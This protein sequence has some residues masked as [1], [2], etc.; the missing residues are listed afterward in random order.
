MSH[1]STCTIEHHNHGVVVRGHLPLSD[2]T[3]LLKGWGSENEEA[4]I[5]LVLTDNLKATLVVANSKEDAA[6]WKREL[7]IREDNPDWLKSGRVGI[8][9]KTIYAVFTNNWEI[10][11]R[12]KDGGNA[13]MDSDDFGRCVFLLD[14]YPAWRGELSRVA[15]ACKEFAPLVPV[16]AE[17]EHL[18][19]AGCFEQLSRR[20]SDLRFP[21]G[22]AASR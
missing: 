1:L 9:S 2:L 3:T 4:S 11:Q 12:G 18:Y 13:P 7:D 19:A 16:W 17:L 8:S 10:L 21:N 15:E 22:R 20:I 6:A 14:R 5:D